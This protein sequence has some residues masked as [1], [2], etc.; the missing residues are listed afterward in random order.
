MNE[1]KI[2]QAP[3]QTYIVGFLVLSSWLLLYAFFCQLKSSF[4]ILLLSHMGHYPQ[5]CDI[6]HMDVLLILEWERVS[7]GKGKITY[8]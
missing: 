7:E 5:R 6:R 2:R 4:L 8:R 3:H 1:R